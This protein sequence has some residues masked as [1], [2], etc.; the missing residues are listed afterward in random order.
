[1]AEKQSESRIRHL[2]TAL[3]DIPGFIALGELIRRWLE[4]RLE[5][6]D[7]NPRKDV[8]KVI[9]LLEGD[10]AKILWARL[11]RASKEA[12]PDFENAVVSALGDLL[13]RDDKT[14]KVIEGEA[15]EIYKWV[16][17]L[18]EERFASLVDA[19]KHNPFG[20]VAKYLI[21]DKGLEGLKWIAG[22]LF[23]AGKFG[24]QELEDFFNKLN[25]KL[26]P[27]LEKLEKRAAKKGVR[28]WLDL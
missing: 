27:R 7:I 20:Q 26:Q 21:T 10:E 2:F 4:K 24:C 8:V 16:A 14:G 28:A 19:M 11:E 9:R 25:N 13:P 12:E 1:M 18:S 17:C 23:G 22:F 3:G 6:F 15:K 5:K